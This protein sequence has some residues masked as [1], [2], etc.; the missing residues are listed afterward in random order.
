[1]SCY[2]FEVARAALGTTR[3][4]E[5]PALATLLPAAGAAVLTVDKFALPENTITYRVAGGITGY[6]HFFPTHCDRG[7]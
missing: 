6:C 1:M 5:V 2:S 7:V 3:V 4:I